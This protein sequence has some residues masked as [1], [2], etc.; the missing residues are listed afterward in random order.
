[1]RGP[2]AALLTHTV[3]VRAVTFV[4][5]STPPGLRGRAMSLRPTGNRFGQVLLP[6]AAGFAAA[7]FAARHLHQSP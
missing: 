6:A 1:M 5:R 3:V 2:T 7:G 4:L